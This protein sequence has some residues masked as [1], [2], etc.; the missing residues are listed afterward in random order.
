MTATTTSVL[1]H[2]VHRRVNTALTVIAMGL[3][4]YI[5][6]VP[7]LPAL[8]WYLGHHPSKA[9]MARQVASIQHAPIAADNSLIIPRLDLHET[10][11]NGPTSAELEKGAWLTPGSARPDEGGNSVIAGH[12]FTLTGQGV[13]YFLD[14]VQVHDPIIITWNHKE[15]TYK[16]SQIMVVPPTDIAVAAPTQHTQLTLYTCTPLWTDRSR[17]VVIAPLERIRS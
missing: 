7:V 15:Y 2:S 13:F 17:L 14:K 5:S 10:I 1:P 4:L 9:A 3:G 16:V 11:Y 8:S 6:I 12:R